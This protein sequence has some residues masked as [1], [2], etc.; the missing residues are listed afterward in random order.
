MNKFNPNILRTNSVLKPS[1]QT[2]KLCDLGNQSKEKVTTIES[3]LGKVRNQSKAVQ[4]L[5]E[6]QFRYGLRVSEVLNIRHM[7]IKSNGMVLVKG[8]KGSDSRVVYVF[9][10][11]EYLNFCKVNKIDPF[12]DLDRF[13][14]YRLYKSVGFIYQSKGSS[15]LSVTHSFRHKIIDSMRK[16]GVENE[17]TAKFIGH[18]SEKNTEN[19]GG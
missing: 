13:F 5:V 12:K 14:L 3:V 16:S 7:H 8:L 4:A 15:K 17:E 10:N 18:K 2:I 1:A 11:W 19:Y 6:L 9:N